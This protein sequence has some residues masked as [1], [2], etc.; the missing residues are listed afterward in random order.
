[1]PNSGLLKGQRSTDDTASPVSK[2]HHHGG[3]RRKHR[4]H[5]SRLRASL[6]DSNSDSLAANPH[7]SSRR[8]SSNDDSHSKVDRKSTDN[9]N[10]SFASFT[11]DNRTS[12]QTLEEVDSLLCRYYGPWSRWRPCNRK[13]HQSRVR[14]CRVAEQCGV[15]K[16]KEHRTCRRKRGRC[17]SRV[18]YHYLHQATD[19]LGKRNRLIQ[20]VLYDVLYTSWSSWGSCTR[21]C[22]QRRRRRCTVHE[23]CRNSYIQDSRRCSVPGTKCQRRN[24]AKPSGGENEEDT[25]TVEQQSSPSFSPAPSSSVSTAAEETTHT[26]GKSRPK[27]DRTRKKEKQKKGG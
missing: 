10:P 4:R 7:P 17:S 13:C 26:K 11:A 3:S 27:A 20:R 2:L 5:L 25:H 16:L 23:V 14:R 19:S 22:R 15:T 9:C 21:S 1:M 6:H 24:A 12:L 8:S 18:S